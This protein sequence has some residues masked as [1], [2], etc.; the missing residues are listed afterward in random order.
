MSSESAACSFNMHEFLWTK[1]H[2][3]KLKTYECSGDVKRNV[4]EG[5]ITMGGG[6]GVCCDVS[7]SSCDQYGDGGRSSCV[8]TFICVVL[9]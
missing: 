3:R 2:F 5:G 4:N 9:S 7:G 6:N 1:M 8:K